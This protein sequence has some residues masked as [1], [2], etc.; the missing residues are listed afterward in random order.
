MFLVLHHVPDKP[1]AAAEIARV[2]RPGGRLLIR[3]TFADRLPDLLWHRYFPGARRVESVLFP[4]L[5]EV[6]DVF[7]RAGLRRV[8][9]EVV[10]ERYA[11]SL[12]EYAARLK[13]RAISTFEYLSDE[14]TRT[15]FAALDAAAAAEREAEPV[16]G[17]SDLLVL[18]AEQLG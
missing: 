11:S 3:S 18:E 4:G 16:E 17:D 1:A 7:A 9:L 14:E 15:G 8:A 2:L 12:K 10:R 13:L 5:D 6:V